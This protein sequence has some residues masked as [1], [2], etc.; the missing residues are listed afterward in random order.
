M[1]ARSIGPRPLLAVGALGG[2]ALLGSACRIDL[3]LGEKVTRE[4]E[5]TEFAELEIDGPF[6]VRVELGEE[7]SVTIEAHEEIERRLDVDQD[8]DRLSIG[9][10]GGLISTSGDLDATI[11]VADLSHLDLDGA[12]SVD[13]GEIDLDRLELDVDGAS[14]VDGR[15]SVGVLVID[16]DGAS[17]IDFGDVTIDSVEIDADGA[18]SIDVTGAD[19]VTGRAN[20]ASSI[21][22]SDEARVDVRTSGASSVD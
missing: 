14:R 4:F 8:G 17:R 18:S 9:F 2:L 7:P 1:T 6:D 5:V 3:D 11:T 16:A 15:G 19:E 13:L 12:T 21:D 20:G 22:V 10:D